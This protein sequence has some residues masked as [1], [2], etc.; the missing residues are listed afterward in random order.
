MLLC[1]VSSFS[2]E[3]YGSA[4]STPT[5]RRPTTRRARSGTFS[6]DVYVDASTIHLVL[7]DYDGA[8]KTPQ[9]YHRRSDDGGESWSASV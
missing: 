2:G 7:A 9:L 3:R 5:H 6:F 1:S 8:S 4:A